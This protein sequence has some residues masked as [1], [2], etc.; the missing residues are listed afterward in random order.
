[1]WPLFI[2]LNPEA[3]KSSLLATHRCSCRPGRFLLERLVHPFVPSILFRVTWLYE[4]RVNA[5]ANPPNGEPAQSADGSRGK[6]HAVVGA[7]NLGET[8]FFEESTK[9]R[10][11][12]YMSRGMQPPAPQDKSRATVGGSQR[13]AVQSITSLELTFKVDTPGV[14]GRSHRLDGPPSMAWIFPSP[15]PVDHA[16]A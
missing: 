10:L 8:V 12:A 7:N 16:V 13:V 2:E 9:Y 15:L 3:I 11:C 5:Q 14:V 1:M 4:L 6:R